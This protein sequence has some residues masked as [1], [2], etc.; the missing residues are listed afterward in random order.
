MD[1]FLIE[2]MSGVELKLHRPRSAGKV[3]TYDAPWE[4]NTSFYTNIIKDGDRLRM[5]FRGSNNSAYVDKGLLKPGEKQVEDHPFTIAYA[6]SRDGIVWERPSLGLWEFQGS[7]DNSIVWMDNP[8]QSVTDCMYVFKDGNPAAP[9]SQRYKALGGS[10]YP[11]VALVS[12]DGFRWTEMQGQ[13][14]LIRKVA[15]PERLRR[16]QRGLLGLDPEA[17]Q[18]LLPRF[19]PGD[20]PPLAPLRPHGGA[21]VQLREPQLQV[22]HVGGFRQLEHAPVGRFSETPPPNT[23]TPMERLP[24]TGRLTSTWLFPSASSP[25]GNGSPRPPFPA[26]PRPSF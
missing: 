15:S 1:D 9:D 19:G 7:K 5:Y 10:S 21:A 24:T 18:H 6:E 8:D 26:P 16:P 3:L 12:P 17:L 4:G 13:K 11:L 2:R 20:Q 25:G 23:S 14:S 22:R